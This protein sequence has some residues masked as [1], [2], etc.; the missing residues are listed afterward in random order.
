MKKIKYKCEKPGFK[1]DPKNP[2]KCIKM[3][4]EEIKARKKAAKVA[5]KKRKA[6]LAQII[7]KAQKTKAKNA[8]KGV[9][10]IIKKVK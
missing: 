4:P 5:A 7:K 6:K 2:K 9:K 3:S 1:I 10:T 8:A